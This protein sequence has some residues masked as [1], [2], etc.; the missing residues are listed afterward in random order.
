M[1]LVFLTGLLI[2]SLAVLA[3]LELTRTRLLVRGSM[4]LDR[5]LAG[6]LLA[7]TWRRGRDTDSAQTLRGFDVFRQALLALGSSRSSTYLG[8]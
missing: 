7:A 8:P 3:L 2:A 1:T 5:E 6:Y 4:R